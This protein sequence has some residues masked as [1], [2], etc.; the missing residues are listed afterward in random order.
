MKLPKSLPVS[1]P[2]AAYQESFISGFGRRM[3]HILG[4]HCPDE[5]QTVRRYIERPGWVT[6]QSCPKSVTGLVALPYFGWMREG[7]RKISAVVFDR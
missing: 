6:L 1:T 7:K 3:E 5:S 2:D 4:V